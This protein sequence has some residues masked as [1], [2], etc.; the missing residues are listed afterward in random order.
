[1][2]KSILTYIK[3]ISISLILLKLIQAKAVLAQIVPDNTLGI[4]KSQVIIDR[5]VD[6]NSKYV[7]TGGAVRGSNLF[8]SFQKFNVLAHQTI[9]FDS[10][11]NITNTLSRVT[12]EHPSYILGK[13]GIVG[14]SNLFFINPNGII[15]GSTSQL[16][17]KGSF[18][19]STASSI[20]LSDGNYFDASN[21]QKAPLLTS[22][23]PIGLGFTDHPG[24]IQVHGTGH[25]LFQSA[26]IPGYVATPIL[27]AANSHVGLRVPKQ[28]SIALIGGDV[29]FDGGIVTAPL[30]K[31]EVG[32]VRSG[33]VAFDLK[34][35]GFNYSSANRFLNIEFTN[36]ALLD[37]SGSGGSSYIHLEAEKISLLE[38][39]YILNQSLT[40]NIRG[41][42]SVNA[43]DTLLM[44][45]PT[46]PN[47]TSSSANV[48]NS[49]TGIVS[50]ALSGQGA[51]ISISTN[52]LNLQLAA[53][54][55]TYGFLSGQGGNLEIKATELTELT[56]ISLVDPIKSINS[57]ATIST[58]F[59]NGGNLNISTHRLLIRDGG[60]V[61]TT[62]L[63]HGQSGDLN[64]DVEVVDIAGRNTVS[65]SPSL[66]G[67][68]TFS[69][70]TG[71]KLTVN[72]RQL[73][74][75]DGGG[76]V[77]STQ[78][79]GASGDLEINAS[80]FVDVS[81]FS[82]NTVSEATTPS[83]ILASANFADPLLR[84][85]FKLP[86][87]PPGISG[88]LFINT[89]KFSISDGALVSVRND[90]NESAGNLTINADRVSIENGA[91]LTATSI[92]GEAGTIS[93]T[94]PF[95]LIN[96]RGQVTA[97]TQLGNG[98]DINLETQNLQ[99]RNGSSITAT[100]S[101]SG[102]GG[103]IGIA[104]DTLIVLEN[105]DIIAN[106]FAGKGGRI[107]IDAQAIF[108]TEARL[109]LTPQSDI[110]ADSGVG[111]DGTVEI[112]TLD[113]DA[114]N[115]LT[116]LQSNFINTEDVVARSCLTRR[117]Q[118]QGSLYINQPSVPVTP[119]SG[120]SEWMPTQPQST[121]Q[122]DN[123]YPIEAQ[124][125]VKLA[126]GRLI[127][128][129]LPQTPTNAEELVCLQEVPSS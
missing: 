49:R 20:K 93:I 32:S 118:S 90:G 28:Q 95:I 19:A 73:I 81:G 14:N 117:N 31:I 30:G 77:T 13:L 43:K 98:G 101:G 92:T 6:S 68:V 55:V 2:T 61:T 47:N 44:R 60:A 16:D 37:S 9:Y 102:D 75:Q 104:T 94:S 23:L 12:G 121:T 96:N 97:E 112:T 51:D 40:S 91:Q 89:P 34:N 114:R 76:V 41:S 106:A 57:I 66:V 127:L 123:P 125:I 52:K 119:F 56:G 72:T 38:G 78:G 11:K 54:I 45:G 15:F 87:I 80:E 108:G 129:N 59:A 8:H 110:T 122:Q 83:F 113:F 116:P 84:Q 46:L 107:Q 26:E 39:S 63:G 86:V 1:M 88:N 128:G 42:I 103:N 33:Y 62:T 124:G 24:S 27:G 29:L 21:P 82:R 126:D 99:L 35:W 48:L 65:L 10:P 22:S 70:G 111:I 71:G 25:T 3:I 5:D 85:L 58:D 69:S 64:A 79:V 109:G 17:V 120:M 18:L 4:E 7:I 74:V 53:G 105:S 67:A 36:R 115:S 100:A 50:Q